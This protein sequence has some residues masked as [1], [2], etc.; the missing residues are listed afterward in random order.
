VVFGE[1]RRYFLLV[2]KRALRLTA[3]ATDS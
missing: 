2:P 3:K 1:E